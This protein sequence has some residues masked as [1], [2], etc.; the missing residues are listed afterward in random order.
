MAKNTV[1]IDVV[2]DDK[3]TTKKVA[4]DAKKLSAALEENAVATTKTYRAQQ[5]MAQNTSNSTKAFAKQAQGIN[6]FL[7]LYATWA[8]N[9]FAVSAAFQFLKEASDVTNLIA[10][11]EA[12]TQTTGVAYKTLTNNIREA[13]DGQ[14]SYAEAARAAAIGSA[15]GLTS[16][17]LNKLGEGAKNASIVLGRDLTDSFNRLIRGVTKAEP[18]LLDELGIVLRLED[19]T[20]R[21]ADALGLNAKELTTYERTQAVANEVLRQTEEKFAKIQGVMDP[22]AASLNRFLVSFDNLINSLKKGTIQAL[23]P[24]FDALAGNTSAL[25]SGLTLVSYYM[26]RN[27]LP[28]F[29]QLGVEAAESAKKQ[30]EALA[31]I[32]VEAEKAK[33]EFKQ[34]GLTKKEALGVESQRAQGALS[35]IDTSKAKKES[36][37]SFLTGTSETAK[38]AANA[39]KI[40]ANAEAQTRNGALVTKG[41][42]A[43]LNQ[44]QVAD[45]RASYVQKKAIIADFE[46]KHT[47]MMTRLGM[48]W[49]VYRTTAVAALASVRSALTTFGA[50]LAK[51]GSRALAAFGWIG[52]LYTVGS[53]AYDIYKSFDPAAKAIDDANKKTESFIDKTAN[54][55]EE[56][57]ASFKVTQTGLESMSESVVRIGNAFAGASI[58]SAVASFNELDPNSEK[59][60]EAKKE[61][62][63]TLNVLSK[64]E[65]AVTKYAEALRNLPKGEK[66]QVVGLADIEEK[67]IA[68]KTAIEAI[69]QGMQKVQD[70]L[71]KL[72]GSGS[73]LDPTETIRKNLDQVLKD[74]DASIKNI[75]ERAKEATITINAAEIVKLMDLESKLTEE[76]NK[77]TAAQELY[78][79]YLNNQGLMSDKGVESLRQQA[80]GQERVVSEVEKQVAAQR[81][82]VDSLAAGNRITEDQTEQLRKQKEYILELKR[83]YDKISPEILNNQAAAQ[84]ARERAAAGQT[85]G[86]NLEQKLT[87][88][89]LEREEATA[90]LADARI[91]KAKALAAVTESGDKD[92]QKAADETLAKADSD[93]KILESK[94]ALEER[95]RKLQEEQLR[96]EEDILNLKIKQTNQSNIISGIEQQIQNVQS[97]AAGLVGIEA[98]KRI[99]ELTKLLNEA[100]L[101][102]AQQKLEETAAAYTRAFNMFGRGEISSQQLEATRVEYIQAAQQKSAAQGAVTAENNRADNV[103]AEAVAQTQLNR[104]RYEALS[105][106][107]VE[108]RYREALIDLGAQGE[109][110][111]ET[112]LAGLHAQIVAQ[113]ELAMQ[114]E[115]KAGLFETINSNMSSALTGLIDGTKS[116]KQAF[117]DM[118]VSILRDLAA[119]I[120][121]ALIFKAI[122]T[123]LPGMGG[124][125]GFFASLFGMANGGVLD[126]GFRAFANGGTV[127]SPTLGLVG[128]GKYNEAIVPLPDGRSIPVQ[129]Q[130]PT[131]PNQQ[132][133]NNV[134]VNVSMDS[135]GNGKTTMGS[136]SAQA[137]GLGKAIAAAVQKE[138]QNQ[139][140]A[141]GMLN[142]YG[143][144]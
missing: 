52:V 77:Q 14:L 70:E 53:I 103:V 13:T 37:I 97:G 84:A 1:Y 109:A 42:L 79:R 72:T 46:M 16:A 27:L 43:G 125:G 2:V 74:I 112:Q 5:G 135:S 107:P 78:N 94:L 3:G 144:A 110:L 57:N 127:K 87:N 122:Q 54:L 31:D 34:L 90:R 25:L 80:E 45:L 7:S 139:K 102:L 120:A 88:L 32:R 126:G 55:N 18:E 141:G 82:V 6:G 59:Y 93:L 39:E 48:Q 131:G 115:M 98:E 68:A 105:I 91:A 119:M 123:A 60:A 26:V 101:V 117:G 44:Q 137:E 92:A 75:E 35:G 86:L 28:N 61:L 15:A 106:N 67:A 8:A 96:F 63:D 128:E 69:P 33:T 9:V 56:L 89:A 95:S 66:L 133:N 116:L 40:I 138:I 118:A 49:K 83:N 99:L 24:V 62:Q 142:A 58:T 17:Q 132:Q 47:S 76:K 10:G 64:F 100:N 111:N 29:S 11:Q 4:M 20:K 73:P 130:S 19:A 22:S 143:A 50:F 104:A 121:K 140:R 36:G 114:T 65:P 51:W 41:V 21:Y 136:N 108:Q 81:E 71:K 134:V 30:K 38:A 23:R 124:G 113:E 85:L 129:M 12:L